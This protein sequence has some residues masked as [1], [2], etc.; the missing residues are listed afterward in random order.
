MVLVSVGLGALLFWVCRWLHTDYWIA[1]G[2]FVILAGVSMAIYLAT[3]QR[4]DGIAVEHAET[5]TRELCKG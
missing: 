1:A 2:V 3:L 5:L 4:L